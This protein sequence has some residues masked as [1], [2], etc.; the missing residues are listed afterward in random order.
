MSDHEHDA[1]RA[2]F[3]ARAEGIHPSAELARRVAAIK[4]AASGR[5]FSL[6]IA[7]LAA[8]GL[9]I[10]AATALV[11]LIGHPG[12]GPEHPAPLAPPAT[13]TPASPATPSQPSL[14]PLPSTSS[15]WVSD[16]WPSSSIPGGPEPSSPPSRTVGSVPE[17][18]SATPS[19]SVPG[20]PVPSGSGR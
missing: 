20:G 10:G 4:P 6:R 7:A 11:L 17:M 14:T 5:R 2:H 3:A 16:S 8:G 9:A 12:S 19:T 13:G 1:L 18:L 15:P